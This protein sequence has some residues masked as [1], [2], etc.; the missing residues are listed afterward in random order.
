MSIRFQSKPKL[1]IF[2]FKKKSNYLNDPIIN[3][4]TESLIILLGENNLICSSDTG[5]IKFIKRLDYTA[6]CLC[7]FVVGWYWGM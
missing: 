6:I 7:S 3:F 5:K 1:R 2:I 4:S